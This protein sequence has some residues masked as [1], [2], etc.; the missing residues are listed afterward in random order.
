MYWTSQTVRRVS[1]HIE[2]QKGGLGFVGTTT[3]SI[4]VAQPISPI[5]I[6]AGWFP[7]SDFLLG[8]F[9]HFSGRT[10]PI[11]ESGTVSGRRIEIR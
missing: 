8:L 6:A 3:G 5:G 1:E 11:A 10:H 2:S 7:S 4:W 9:D